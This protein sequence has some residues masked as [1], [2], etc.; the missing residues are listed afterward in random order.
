M[1]DLAEMPQF[2]DSNSTVGWTPELRQPTTLF[3]NHVRGAG[4]KPRTQVPVVPRRDSFEMS[5]LEE[6]FHR[7]NELASNHQHTKAAILTDDS[8]LLSTIFP[9]HFEILT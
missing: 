3:K 9:A 8:I 5:A 4:Q 7:V 6:G 1:Y 2:C